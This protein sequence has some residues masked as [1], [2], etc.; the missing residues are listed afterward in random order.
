MTTEE[1]IK[2][3]L[4]DI[5]V[6][7]NSLELLASATIW[8]LLGVGMQDQRVG[9]AITSELVFMPKINMLRRI[10]NE[11][12]PADMRKEFDS[13]YKDLD[14][15]SNGRNKYIHSLWLLGLGAGTKIL[16]MRKEFTRTGRNN[17]EK[18]F[19][20][21]PIDELREFNNKVILTS[22]ALSNYISRVE[23]LLNMIQG[24]K[25]K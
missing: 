17:T 2:Q 16:D 19:L 15:C 3:V 22:T 23:A 7:F 4:G 14:K 6:S 25:Q 18:A 21:V 24:E 13:I 10:I 12:L 11:K 5:V 8:V 20:L 1:E 9:K